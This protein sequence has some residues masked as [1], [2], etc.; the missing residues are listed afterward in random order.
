MDIQKNYFLAVVILKDLKYLVLKK[1][2]MILADA[3]LISKL[4]YQIFSFKD[5]CSTITI[6]NSFTN[7]DSEINLICVCMIEFQ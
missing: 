2:L 4:H 7:I 1:C 5:V 3:Y 6:S